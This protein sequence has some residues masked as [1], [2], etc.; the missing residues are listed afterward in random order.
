MNSQYD[1]KKNA[2]KIYEAGFPFFF[3]EN[4]NRFQLFFWTD[5][6]ASAVEE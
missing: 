3:H 4:Q 1:L 6:N 5:S 2:F